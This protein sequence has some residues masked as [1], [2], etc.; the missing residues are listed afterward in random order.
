VERSPWQTI[1]DIVQQVGGRSR[2]KLR[3]EVDPEPWGGWLMVPVV[4]YLEAAGSGPWPWGAVEWVE[5]EPSRYE[6]GRMA[7]IFASAGLPAQVVGD[8][9]RVVG[10]GVTSNT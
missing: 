10:T 6:A 3:G 5:V 2:L 4:G 7:A 1:A 8:A 9:V